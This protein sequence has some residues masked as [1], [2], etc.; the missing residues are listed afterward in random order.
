MTTEKKLK[1]QVRQF[2]ERGEMKQEHDRIFL[3]SKTPEELSERMQDFLKRMGAMTNRHSMEDVLAN[4]RYYGA[5][6]SG[7]W[8]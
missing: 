6:Y 8:A 1:Q 3:T 5:I 7:K 2:R 4:Q